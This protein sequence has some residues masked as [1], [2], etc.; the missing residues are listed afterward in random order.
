MDFAI[1]LTISKYY[2]SEQLSNI[3]TG[4]GGLICIILGAILAFYKPKAKE[5]IDL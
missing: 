1:F 3:T 4:F 2:F 5:R